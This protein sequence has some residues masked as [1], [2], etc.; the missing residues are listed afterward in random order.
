MVQARL[1]TECVKYK[2]RP[3]ENANVTNSDRINHEGTPQEL[4][5]LCS[6]LC[7]NFS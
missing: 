7:A 4:D 5:K 2:K 6:V 3:G 1:V